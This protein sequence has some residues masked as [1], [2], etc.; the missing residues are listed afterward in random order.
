MP[1]STTLK[2]GNVH[3]QFHNEWRILAKGCLRHKPR[4]CT[5]PAMNSRVKNCM[6]EWGKHLSGVQPFVSHS[7]FSKGYTQARLL[8]ETAGCSTLTTTQIMPQ[9]VD[10]PPRLQDLHQHNSS[11]LAQPGSYSNLLITAAPRSAEF[12]KILWKYP[13]HFLP[14]SSC[15]HTVFSSGWGQ[16]E[17]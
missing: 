16:E 17:S 11:C 2:S 4:S 15:S 13:L 12:E 3:P 5:Q 7:G 14:V 9:N 8:V 1:R 10:F 6:C